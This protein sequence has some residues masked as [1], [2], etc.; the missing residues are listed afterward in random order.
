MYSNACYHAVFRQFLASGDI[1]SK[2][3]CICLA[4]VAKCPTLSIGNQMSVS[5]EK[6]TP[7]QDATTKI[8][9]C[10]KRKIAF[11]SILR[12]RSSLSMGRITSYVHRG[13]LIPHVAI[14]WPIVVYSIYNIYG[15]KC[16]SWKI[17][18]SSSQSSLHYINYCSSV[19]QQRASAFSY[20]RHFTVSWHC[21]T[22]W[23][24]QLPISLSFHLQ[25][26]IPLSLNH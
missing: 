8:T 20:L 9:P 5:P 19:T 2:R 1:W 3:W 26:S 17:H 15:A 13:Y 12:L 10:H 6:N 25:Q 24:L 14:F 21:V 22:R 23:R 18:H 16:W 7:K 4:P 11:I